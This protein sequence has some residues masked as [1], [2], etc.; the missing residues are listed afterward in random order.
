M[1]WWLEKAGVPPHG[2][3]RGD[4]YGPM[5]FRPALEAGV[6]GVS[7]TTAPGASLAL[8][9]LRTFPAICC[10]GRGDE[11][12]AGARNLS[13]SMAAEWAP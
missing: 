9:G 13:L 4:V 7:L 8:V 12:R 3:G 6:I 1:C 5:L 10:H 11:V 2:L